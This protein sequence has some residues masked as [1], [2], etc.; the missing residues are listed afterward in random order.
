M[1][2]AQVEV[3]RYAVVHDRSEATGMGN[4]AELKNFFFVFGIIPAL[5]GCLCGEYFLNRNGTKYTKNDA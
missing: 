4:P 3:F 5:S 2:A 1:A